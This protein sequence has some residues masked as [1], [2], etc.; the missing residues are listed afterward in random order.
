[1]RILVTG[2]A[3]FIGRE[4]IKELSRL[5][6]AVF[7]VINSRNSL[8][9]PSTDLVGKIFAADI[10][11]FK[12]LAKIESLKKIDAVVH[13]AGLAHQFKNIEREKFRAVNIDGTKNILKLSLKLNAKQFILISSTA[14]YGIK[15][16]SKDEE[17][18]LSRLEIDENTVCQPETLYAESKLQAEDTAR[19]FCEKNKIALSILRLP[20]VIG[21]GNLGNAAR[22]TEAIDKRKFF[23]I[24]AGENLKTFIYKKDVARACGKILLEK[25]GGTEIFNLAADPIKMKDFVAL[26]AGKL[27]KGI[28]KFKIPA[29]LFE[30]FF[31]FNQKFLGLKKIDK[32]SETFKKWLSDDVYSANKI[33]KV[34]NFKPETSIEQAIG[35][36]VDWYRNKRLK[37]EN[38]K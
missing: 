20:P 15:K 32:V 35:K 1:M 25:K 6:L 38:K 31:D 27:E 36:Q 23:W 19:R 37:A 10:T 5:D 30:W 33:A 2:A 3:G 24:G 34:Y 7:Q 8:K 4:I 13:S 29:G 16:N 9:T 18:N 11:D 28:P 14:V 21:E 22:L 26:I 17:N 12:N